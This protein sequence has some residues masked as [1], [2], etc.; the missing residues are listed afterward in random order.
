MPSIGIVSD[1][2]LAA[3]LVPLPGRERVGVR[4]TF[5]SAGFVR[6][7]IIVTICTD[8]NAMPFGPPVRTATGSFS[9]VRLQPGAQK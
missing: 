3:L 7:G 6:I 8:G 2:G 5:D 4:G 1:A 9:K